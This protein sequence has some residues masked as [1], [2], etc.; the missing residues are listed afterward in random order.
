MDANQYDSWMRRRQKQAA[1]SPN[2]LASD[3]RAAERI[4]PGMKGRKVTRMDDILAPYRGRSY[5]GPT[6]PEVV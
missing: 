2:P 4:M 6:E 1:H 5:D 3:N